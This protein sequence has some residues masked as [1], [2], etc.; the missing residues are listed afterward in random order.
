MKLAHRATLD[1][2]AVVTKRLD[3]VINRNKNNKME[4]EKGTK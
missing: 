4:S 2:L 1:T 3:K